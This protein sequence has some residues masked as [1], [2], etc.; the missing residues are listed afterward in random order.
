MPVIVAWD[1]PTRLAAVR[2]TDIYIRS[3]AQRS[4][5]EPTGKVTMIYFAANGQQ[6]SGGGYFIYLLMALFFVALYF[7]MI[8]P[9]QKRRR[10]TESMQRAMGPGDEI[11]TVGG[12]YGTVVDINDDV[13][14][15]EI[16]PGVTARYARA[17]I[18]KVVTPAAR[19]DEDEEEEDSSSDTVAKED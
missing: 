9:Q 5:A 10:A 8:R 6:S 19:H 18:G 4:E 1:T 7:L 14:T 2:F 13:V 12:L 16:A 17:A 11:V 3:A 15:L